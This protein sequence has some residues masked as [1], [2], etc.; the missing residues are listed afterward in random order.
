MFNGRSL[1]VPSCTPFSRLLVPSG[2]YNTALTHRG[3]H[4]HIVG[5]AFPHISAILWSGVLDWLPSSSNEKIHGQYESFDHDFIWSA[6]VDDL[7][8]PS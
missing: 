8:G 1:V 4:C 7:L 3:R 2:V 6:A 5:V